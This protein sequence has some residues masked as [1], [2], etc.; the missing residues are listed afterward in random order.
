[1]N[2]GRVKP[3]SGLNFREK[4]NGELISVLR[5][6]EMVGILETVTFYRVQNAIGE[7]GYVHGDYL[8]KMPSI[9]NHVVSIDKPR[10]FPSDTYEQV[11][12]ENEFFVGEPAKVDRDFVPA[13][14]RVSDYA[15]T[16]KLKVWVT[17]SSRNLGDQV[18]GAIVPPAGRSCHHIG[19][20]IDMNLM[21]DGKLYNSRSLR[22]DNLG[23]L[24]SAISKFIDKI[25]E[26]DELRWGGD[27]S[28]E[29]PVHIDDDF[30]H[31]Q[32]IFYMAK[33]HS[34][35]IQLNA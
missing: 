11:I 30:Y 7:V 18:R 35:V 33:L 21:H 15:K 10:V 25:R 16:N 28:V 8:E 17:S 2:R 29:D 4:P 26:D 34:R 12:F 3:D 19:H 27:F 32:E 22:R 20:A 13:L 24:P 6:N 5:H 23:N 14:K 9:E 1:M 31:R